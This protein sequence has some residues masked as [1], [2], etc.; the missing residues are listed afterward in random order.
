MR[1]YFVFLLI[2]LIV[3]VYSGGAHA[4]A[5]S[6]MITEEVKDMEIVVIDSDPHNTIVQTDFHHIQM[7]VNEEFTYGELTTT[8]LRNNFSETLIIELISVKH[9]QYTFTLEQNGQFTELEL[10]VNILLPS[11]S[12]AV[13]DEALP[14]MQIQNVTTFYWDSVRYQSGVSPYPRPDHQYYGMNYWQSRYQEGLKLT[15]FQYNTAAT[16]VLIGASWFVIGTALGSVSSLV[17]GLSAP[18]V[19][20]AIGS[21]LAI[22]GVPFTGQNFADER[23]CL[24]VQ[25]ANTASWRWI[26]GQYG[27]FPDY[28]RVGPY[29]LWNYLGPSYNQPQSDGT[30]G[31]GGGG[32]WFTPWSVPSPEQ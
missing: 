18:L 20:A 2:L 24:W 32:G 17:F 7:F 10:P 30:G 6:A 5:A 23:G 16:N 11:S 14:D 25:H 12:V 27:R 3:F 26:W 1:K 8:D 29:T 15:H 4:Q 9:G 13:N 28:Y 22:V 19:G 21:G 31:G